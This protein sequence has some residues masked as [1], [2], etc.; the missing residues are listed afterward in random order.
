MCVDIRKYYWRLL[1]NILVELLLLL[2]LLLP[3]AAGERARVAAHR[4]AE[5]VVAVERMSRRAG[6]GLVRGRRRGL[7]QTRRYRE[8]DVHLGRLLEPDEIAKMIGHCVEN[9]ALNATTIEITGG[10]CYPH[11]IA[12]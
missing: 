6:G 1:A 2:L 3:L 8:G 12:K 4:Q 9:S 5:H 7:W 10:L 11:G